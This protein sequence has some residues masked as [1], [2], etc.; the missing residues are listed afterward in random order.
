MDYIFVMGLIGMIMLVSSWI[1]Q[2]LET[3]KT[4]KCPL[5]LNF[6]LLYTISSF[7]LTVYSIF[8]KDFIF[9]VLNFLAF[10]QSTINLFVKLSGGKEV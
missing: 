10:L 2:T 7:L 5:N 6:V 1:P 9:T 3:I 4:K 8:I